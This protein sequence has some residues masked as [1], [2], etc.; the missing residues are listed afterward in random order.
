MSTNFLDKTDNMLVINSVIRFSVQDRQ[1]DLAK[2]V[3]QKMDE[4]NLSTYDVER[5]SGGTVTHGTVW[6]ILN[7]RV[8]DVKSST[9][10]AL[11][12]GLG[13]SVD[14]VFNVYRGGSANGDNMLEEE[15][16]VLFYGW[17]E[18]DEAAKA[19]TLAAIRM[20]AETFQRRRNKKKKR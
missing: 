16:G 13:V 20:I 9:L 15:I 5:R 10:S 11:A 6:N 19:E 4:Q 7:Q 18:A 1:A 2:Y 12:K 17:D 8:K 14:E 3:R